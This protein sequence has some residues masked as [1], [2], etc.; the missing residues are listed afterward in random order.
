MKLLSADFVFLSRGTTWHVSWKVGIVEV[1]AHSP[2]R[3]SLLFKVDNE[4]RTWKPCV[5]HAEDLIRLHPWS[6]G[7]RCRCKQAEARVKETRPMLTLYPSGGGI[8]VS[9]E[10]RVARRDR[11]LAECAERIKEQRREINRL[12]DEA[13]AMEHTLLE[14]GVVPG[15]NCAC[16][17]DDCRLVAK[18][19][20]AAGYMENVTD[21][22]WLDKP[23]EKRS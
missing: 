20:D 11:Q 5:S 3:E 23:W 4:K 1:M 21:K 12:R 22:W 9:A 8:A 14:A 18:S 6:K 17:C 7:G 2:E 16:R 13:Q 15:I 19:M 10:E